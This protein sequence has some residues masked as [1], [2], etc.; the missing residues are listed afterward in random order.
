MPTKDLQRWNQDGSNQEGR[1]EAAGYEVDLQYAST[2]GQTQVSQ[3]ENMI[4]NGCELLVIASIDGSSREP[5]G[6]AKEAGIRLF[7]MTALM[8][9]DAVGILRNL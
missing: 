1:A 7:P 3:V 4:S 9:S 5:L 2:M 8:N 6:Q